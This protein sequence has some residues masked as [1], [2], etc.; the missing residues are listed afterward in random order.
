MENALSAIW[1]YA[2]SAL[3]KLPP[4]SGAR[5]DLERIEDA[6]DRALDIFSGP[7]LDRASRR[8]GEEALEQAEAVEGPTFKWTAESLRSCPMAPDQKPIWVAGYAWLCPEPD[9]PGVWV[10]WRYSPSADRWTRFPI[11]TFR[12]RQAQRI[13]SWIVGD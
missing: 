7:F 13:A 12:K 3:G 9:D 8:L 4:D 11:R 6:S 1:G 10:L 2:D 5:D